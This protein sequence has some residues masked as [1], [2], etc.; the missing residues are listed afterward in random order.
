[1]FL[2][3]LQQNLLQ[4][5]ALWRWGETEADWGGSC[6]SHCQRC[7]TYELCRVQEFQ[8]HL[9]KV[10]QTQ[11]LLQTQY[12]GLK[13]FWILNFDL[14]LFLAQLFSDTNFCW[15]KIVLEP[16]FYGHRIFSGNNLFLAQNLV[17][18]SLLWLQFFSLNFLWPRFFEA[19]F[20]GPHIF[21]YPKFFGSPKFMGPNIIWTQ[22]VSTLVI[23]FW[24]QCWI[25]A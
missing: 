7:K 9:Q 5:Y 6:Y 25:M 18:K 8:D 16:L 20:F 22:N 12:M 10:F 13:L 4:V 21:W 19:L 3:F 23:K 2:K 15:P 1:M 24:Y 17:I 14:K 11:N